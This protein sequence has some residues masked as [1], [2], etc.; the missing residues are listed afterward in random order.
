MFGQFSD[1]T[2]SA[3]PVTE[4]LILKN[5]MLKLV[6]FTEKKRPFPLGYMMSL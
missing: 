1:L 4:E 6:L 3:Y 2:I 5:I